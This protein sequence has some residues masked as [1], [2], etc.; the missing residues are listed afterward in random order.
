MPTISEYMT[1]DHRQCDE[2]LADAEGLVDKSQWDEA[3]KKTQDFVAAM[4]RH[5]LREE[6]VLFPVFE[7]VSGITHGPTQVMREEHQQIRQLL[8]Q[9]QFTVDARQREEYLDSADTL[10][11]MIQQHNAKEEGMLYPMSDGQLAADTDQVIADMEQ[12]A[13]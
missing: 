8:M 5:F 4:E 11:I 3:Q 2:L 7:Q 12:V 6:Q 13:V 1:R 10:L 9:L